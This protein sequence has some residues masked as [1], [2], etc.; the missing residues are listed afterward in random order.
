MPNLPMHTT[1]EEAELYWAAESKPLVQAV[2]FIL[3]RV[4]EIPPGIDDEGFA[5]PHSLEHLAY[6]VIDAFRD[7][8]R[9]LHPP[10]S[11]RMVKSLHS[12][13]KSM[14]TA[15]IVDRLGEKSPYAQDLIN[16]LIDGGES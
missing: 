5:D 2:A 3:E 13:P 11:Q 10:P 4:F 16:A 6:G 12:A 15:E 8:R 1:A 14:L 9:G 7:A